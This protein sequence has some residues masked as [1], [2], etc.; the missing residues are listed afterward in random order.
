[1]PVVSCLMFF[2]GFEMGGFQLVLR[3]VSNEFSMASLGSGLLVAAQSAG[4]IFMPLLLGNLSDR[5]GKKRILLASSL[6]FLLGC[7]L[8]AAAGDAWVFICG[9]FCIGAGYSTFECTGS[10]ALAD[11]F[12]EKSAK[13]I[14]LSQCMLSLG[15]V[16]SPVLMQWC[17]SQFS[18]SWRAVFLICGVAYAVLLFPV[19]NIRFRK[20]VPQAS[21]ESRMP[22]HTFFGS[23]VFSLLFFS[24]VLYVGLETGIGY[25]AESLFALKLSSDRL[26][27]YAISAY[28]ICMALSRLVCA[29]SS[30]SARKTLLISFGASCVLFAALAASGLPYLSL[31]LCG[32]IGFAFGPAWS[33]LVDLA[34]K[35]F[36]QHTGGAI[37]LMSAGC[38]LGGVV[39]PSLMGFLS[40]QL[41][42]RIAFAMLSVTALAAGIL[43]YLLYRKIK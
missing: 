41:D 35:Q 30:F 19:Y 21:P 33:L 1:M 6:M 7:A 22:V 26:G 2:T 27:A 4:V 17:I 37:G 36:P 42:L 25:F 3:S 40:G 14:N 29:L 13:Y 8:A 9:V 10:A 15:A 34:A 39:F 16:V 12:P 11:E 28:W 5:I 23:T 32:M 20:P 24:I 38:G 31:I 18:W 43:V